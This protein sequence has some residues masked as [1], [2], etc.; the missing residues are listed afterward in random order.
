MENLTNQELINL[1]NECW[2]CK[3]RIR[4]MLSITQ[5]NYGKSHQLTKKILKIE[6]LF[7]IMQ[8]GLDDQVS[9]LFPH[10]VYTLP[11]TDMP[12]TGVFYNSGDKPPLLYP[13]HRYYKNN[14]QVYYLKSLTQL[15]KD[16]IHDHLKSLNSFI[17]KIEQLNGKSSFYN[18]LKRS[19]DR[20]DEH[21]GYAITRPDNEYEETIFDG[22]Y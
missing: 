3:S 8:S 22:Q 11:G 12:I 6:K 9:A 21:I 16:Q 20:F 14:K 2:N 17:Q 1:G 18:T 4:E 13:T 10:N 19:I 7:G 5:Y 15:H